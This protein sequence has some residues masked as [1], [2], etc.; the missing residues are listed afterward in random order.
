M[1][2]VEEPLCFPL[3]KH[4]YF[5]HSKAWQLAKQARNRPKYTYKIDHTELVNRADR[6]V[7]YIKKKQIKMFDFQQQKTLTSFAAR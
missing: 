3:L 5:P 6:A 1:R 7:A 4:F 2:V